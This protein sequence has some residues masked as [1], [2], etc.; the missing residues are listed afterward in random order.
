MISGWN[1]L[2]LTDFASFKPTYLPDVSNVANLHYLLL[3]NS[4]LLFTEM[5]S[6]IGKG[7]LSMDI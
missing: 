1:W 7:Y 3:V 4:C 5:L 2:L 6:T